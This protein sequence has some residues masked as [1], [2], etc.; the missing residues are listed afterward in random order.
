MR[1]KQIDRKELEEQG[2]K[3]VRTFGLGERLLIFGKDN[4]RIAWDCE[5][6]RVVVEYQI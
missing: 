2:W 5:T 4:N 6:R 1:W 3:Y